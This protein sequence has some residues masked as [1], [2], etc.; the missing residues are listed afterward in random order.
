VD[1]H[2]DHCAGGLIGV[3]DYCANEK[4]SR[5]S[6]AALTVKPLTP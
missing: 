3:R 1:V 2:D 5:S 6:F 4:Y